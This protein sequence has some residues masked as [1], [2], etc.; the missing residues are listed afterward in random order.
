MRRA[1]FFE[2]VVVAAIVLGLVAFLSWA[3]RRLT[4]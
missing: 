1:F 4:A 3:T 2:L